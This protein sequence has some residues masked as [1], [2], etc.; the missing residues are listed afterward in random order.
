MQPTRW[1][2]KKERGEGETRA[3]RDLR[4]QWLMGQSQTQPAS[5][6]PKRNTNPQIEKREGTCARAKN[7][8]L[9]NTSC[10]SDLT[11]K[12]SSTLPCCFSGNPP[13]T[14][15]LIDSSVTDAGCSRSHWCSAAG[16]RAAASPKCRN[17]SGSMNSNH[18]LRVRC[19]SK[20]ALCAST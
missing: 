10:C 18:S 5:A 6:T 11:V 13:N 16:V 12:R 7:F 9:P 1:T 17:S 14:M 20:Q 8:S 19:R 2:D 3:S 4:T 15:F